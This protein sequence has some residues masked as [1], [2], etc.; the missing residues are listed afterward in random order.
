MLV[1]NESLQIVRA[2]DVKLAARSYPAIFIQA[3]KHLQRERN[4]ESVCKCHA[5]ETVRAALRPLDYSNQSTRHAREVPRDELPQDAVPPQHQESVRKPP[6]ARR[7]AAFEAVPS[8]SARQH[9]SKFDGEDNG[10]LT[11]GA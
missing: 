5:C 4:G 10:G 8:R 11:A 9:I 7:G 3:A 2:S 1:N 6:A